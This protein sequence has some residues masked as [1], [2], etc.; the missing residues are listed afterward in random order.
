MQYK[1]PPVKRRDWPK[2]ENLS[3][4]RAELAEWGW[5]LKTG[6][7][8]YWY[9]AHPSGLPQLT[10]RQCKRTYLLAMAYIAWENGQTAEALRHEAEA[11]KL[12]VDAITGG[13]E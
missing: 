5:S 12:K 7:G 1:R 4:W 13:E 11:S 3:A 9:A 8:G 10:D 2:E 6:T